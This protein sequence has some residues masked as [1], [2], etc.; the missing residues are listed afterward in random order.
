MGEAIDLSLRH[1]SSEDI[2]ALTRYLRTIP[3]QRSELAAQIDH[4]PATLNGAT[5]WSPG[6]DRNESSGFQIFASACASC[7]GWDGA[8]QQTD[9]A[10]LLGS[11]TVN[12][13]SGVNLVRAVL[14]GVKIGSP[15]GNNLMPSFA[16]AYS[17]AEIAAVSNYVIGH[18]GGKQGRVTSADVRAARN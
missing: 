13:P 4:H 9:H 16:A 17:D 5:T 6:P 14:E 12:D 15:R 18:F 10:E 11:P 1:L 7:H 2:A 3:A 8:G